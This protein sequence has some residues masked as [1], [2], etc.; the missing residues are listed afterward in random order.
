MFWD[1]EEG[2]AGAQKLML[3]AFRAALISMGARLSDAQREKWT[4]SVTEQEASQSMA[5]VPAALICFSIYAYK[6]RAFSFLDLIYI[7]H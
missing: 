5:R 2:K 6:T 1:D 4:L 3:A 7:S